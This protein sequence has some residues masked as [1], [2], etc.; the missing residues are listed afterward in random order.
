MSGRLKSATPASFG[1]SYQPFANHPI[2]LRRGWLRLDTLQAIPKPQFS[3]P[4]TMTIPRPL[5]RYKPV[6]CASSMT[7]CELPVRREDPVRG[8]R[9]GAQYHPCYS[10]SRQRRTLLSHPTHT[11]APGVRVS[12]TWKAC[13][14]SCIETWMVSSWSRASSDCGTN[15]TQR[16]QRSRRSRSLKRSAT[17]ERK[18]RVRRGSSAAWA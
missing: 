10:R 14:P 5:R 16:S 17:V 7:E 4:C 15:S 11:G 6:A 9:S 13:A 1:R 12:A 2:H 18:V 3:N 8:A